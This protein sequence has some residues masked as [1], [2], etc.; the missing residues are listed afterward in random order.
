[1]SKEPPMDAEV[2][3]YLKNES[4]GSLSNRLF[5]KLRY[6]IV[7][8][9]LQPGY[10]FPNEN[11]FCEQLSVG[12]STLREVYKALEAGGFISRT[13]R[14]TFVN[15]KD[16]ILAASPFSMAVENSN[17]DDFTE[18]RSIM[19]AEMA[20]MAAKRATPEDLGEI[21][22]S[23]ASLEACDVS[24]LRK[25]SLHDMQFHLGIAAASKNRLLA[26]TM[27]MIIDP[28]YNGILRGYQNRPGDALRNGILHHR[29]I[30]GFLEAADDRGAY[31]MMRRHI[32]WNFELLSNA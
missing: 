15:S 17:F 30:L 11:L 27:Q 10:M 31:D 20:A 4:A 22:K 29:E 2:F 25:C 21:R 23:I 24:D 5:E 9:R 28:F 1:M 6:M 32:R 18:F 26:N 19:E 7:T 16:S 14:G 12:R 3:E 8:E 13:K